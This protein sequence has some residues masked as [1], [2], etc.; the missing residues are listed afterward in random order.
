MVK[1]D[2]RPDQVIHALIGR[3]EPNYERILYGQPPLVITPD[4]ST[5]KFQP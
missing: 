3:M 5:P 2:G 4:G 1:K